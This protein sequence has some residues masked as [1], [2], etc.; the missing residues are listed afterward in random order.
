MP[1]FR[2]LSREPPFGR[3]TVISRAEDS[4]A[5]KVQWRC[6]CTCGNYVTVLAQ[7]L[8]A[9]RTQS[10]GCWHRERTSKAHKKHGMYGH[11]DYWTWQDMWK[12]C[13]NERH[14]G[15]KDYGGRGIRVCKRWRDFSNFVAD[16]GPRPAGYLLDRRNNNGDYTPK[17]CRWASPSESAR[18]TRRA[19]RVTIG[20]DTLTLAAWAE[21][22]G[23]RYR[24]LYYRIFARGWSPRRAVLTPIRRRRSPTISCTVRTH[25]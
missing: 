1:A 16:M 18:N 11:R 13:T 24:T 4:S 21:R 23:M 25:A 8:V 15:W 2:D 3:L 6:C 22:K 7:S 17:N 9:G 12:R 10:C 19:T 14:R 20:R 5:G